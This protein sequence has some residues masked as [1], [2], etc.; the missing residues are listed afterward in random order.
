VVVVAGAGGLIWALKARRSAPQPPG[1]EI[2]NRAAPTELTQVLAELDRREPGW[3]LDGLES[4][5]QVLPPEQNSALP[6]LA[7]RRLFDER[8]IGTPLQETVRNQPPSIQFDRRQT[9]ALRAVL[10]K[11]RPAL[12]E[13]RRVADLPHGRYPITYARGHTPGSCGT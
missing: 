3:R 1:R 9:A 10:Q 11:V 13:A 5:R 12:A 6:I 8:R 2:A 7:A 4:Q